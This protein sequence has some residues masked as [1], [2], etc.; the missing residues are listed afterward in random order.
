MGAGDINGSPLWR[1]CVEEY[2]GETQQFRISV[3]G[4]YRND[5]VLQR[6][7]N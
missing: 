6:Y 7:Q 3:T 5:T 2:G 4:S 1:D